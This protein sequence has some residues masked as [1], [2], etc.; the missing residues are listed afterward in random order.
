MIASTQAEGQDQ[1]LGDHEQLDVDRERREEPGQ[2]LP[3]RSRPSRNDSWTSGQPGALTTIQASPPKT[4]T[5]LTSAMT[6]ERTA[7]GSGRRAA[8][9]RSPPVIVAAVLLDGSGRPATA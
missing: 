9:R 5:V 1:D 7:R 8:G 3:R 2:R 6:L 4:T